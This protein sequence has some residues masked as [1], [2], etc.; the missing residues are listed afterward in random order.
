MLATSDPAR[1]D[2][3]ASAAARRRALVAM[4]LAV[5]LVIAAVSA[6]NLALPAIAIELGASNRALT[7]IAD[8]YTVALA[9][10]VLPFGALGDRWGRRRILVVGCAVFGAGALASAASGSTDALILGR[11]VMGVGAAMI[12]PSTLS[13][14]TASFPTED[15]GRGVATWAGFAGAGGVIGLIAAGLLLEWWGWR[16]IF[17]AS[18]LTAVVAAAAALLL[19][20]E[21]HSDETQRFDFV[22]SIL[23][24]VG[25]GAL[26]FAIIDGADE[27][28]TRVPMSAA[29]VS[30]GCAAGF[31]VN[32]L[33]R[34]DPIL[35][36]RLFLRTR[37]SAGAITIL[38]QFMAAFGFFFVG[39]QF[40]LL[41]LGWSPLHAALAMAPI[42]IVVL[43]AAQLTPKLVHR[44]GSRAVMTVGLMLLAGGMAL[45]GRFDTTSTYTAFLVAMV[46]AAVG[47]GLT[48]AAAT[49]AIV[50]ELPLEQQGVASAVNDATREIGA[51][52]GIAL[53]G[54][55]YGRAYREALP[56]PPEGAPPEIVEAVRSSAIAGLEVAKRLGPAGD[57]VA[58]AVRSAFVQGLAAACTTVAVLLIV[59]AAAVAVSRGLASLPSRGTRG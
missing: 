45:V 48:S 32:G 40:L 18:A 36:P 29:I 20:A 55:T 1:F 54:A 35:D 11:I 26:V 52:L 59:A 6:L 30:V 10:L 12:M 14:I 5:V 9:A 38:V 53:M 3:A 58:T 15:R 51:A 25:I 42:G 16:S 4:C 56:A 46:I 8:G 13:T 50:E 19:T 49:A 23:S 43:A 41:I 17:V 57:A 31:L 7:W 47:I 39:L 28:W 24:A 21:T 27:G 37:F 2:E 22:G 44:V 33:R 34:T